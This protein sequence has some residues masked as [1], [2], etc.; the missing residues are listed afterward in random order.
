MYRKY[1][2]GL[3]QWLADC[4]ASRGTITAGR[5]ILPIL[6]VYFFCDSYYTAQVKSGKV[7][8]NF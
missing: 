4:H 5:G 6:R 1:Q 8:R 2:A 3:V 7:P